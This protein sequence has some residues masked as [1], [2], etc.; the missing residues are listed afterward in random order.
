MGLGA[1]IPVCPRGVYSLLETFISKL[2]TIENS[3]FKLVSVAEETGL[4]LVLSESPTTGFV[5]SRPKWFSDGTVHVYI[6]QLSSQRKHTID[7]FN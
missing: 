3:I 4:S 2:A 1:R 5:T 7:R 6:Y